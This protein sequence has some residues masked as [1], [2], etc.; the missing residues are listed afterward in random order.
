MKFDL[1]PKI[2]RDKQEEELDRHFCTMA[3]H[4][5]KRLGRDIPSNEAIRRMLIACRQVHQLEVDE[6]EDFLHE[7]LL[8]N[9]IQ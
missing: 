3:I 9:F 6:W 1:Q 5:A 7:Q 4:T 2:A 8:A